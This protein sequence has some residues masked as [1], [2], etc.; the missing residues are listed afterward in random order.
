MWTCATAVCTETI[1]SVAANCSCSRWL[2][3]AVLRSRNPIAITIAVVAIMTIVGTWRTCS[4]SVV[5]CVYPRRQHF[6]T[7]QILGR[8]VT[9]LTFENNLQPLLFVVVIVVDGYFRS[10]GDCT[11]GCIPYR[12]STP[13]FNLSVVYL[14]ICPKLLSVKMIFKTN[15]RNKLLLFII[16]TF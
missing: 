14:T 13:T 6:L 11:K 4:P 5:A 10:G 15:I 3:V 2:C 1:C 12:W 7:W 16:I 9:C 8:N